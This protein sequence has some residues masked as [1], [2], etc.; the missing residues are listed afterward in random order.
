MRLF[1]KEKKSEM[2]HNGR[3]NP[4]KILFTTQKFWHEKLYCDLSLHCTDFFL[5]TKNRSYCLHVLEEVELQMEVKMSS[6]GGEPVFFQECTTRTELK[7]FPCIAE[8]KSFKS[9]G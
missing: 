7:F 8:K 5:E 1:S 9:C 6:G 3:K 4:Q 2:N